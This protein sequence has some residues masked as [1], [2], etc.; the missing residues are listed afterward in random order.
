MMVKEYI[1]YDL[2]PCI[3]GKTCFMALH[4]NYVVSVLENIP[5]VLE[6]NVYILNVE[7]SG[8]KYCLNNYLGGSRFLQ[9]KMS[10]L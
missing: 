4:I 2:N 8:K 3:F 6:K 10:H 7:C 9:R 5:C 1:M